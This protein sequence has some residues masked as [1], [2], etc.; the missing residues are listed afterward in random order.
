MNMKIYNEILET[1]FVILQVCNNLK[2]NFLNVP[3]A[4]LLS[5][6]HGSVA[7]HACYKV[8]TDRECVNRP[9]IIKGRDER[10]VNMC[11]WSTW[12]ALKASWWVLGRW[13]C[14]WFHPVHELSRQLA[15]RSLSLCLISVYFSVFLSHAGKTRISCLRWT[16]GTCCWTRFDGRAKTMRRWATFI[17]TTSSCASCRLVK[18]PHVLWKRSVFLITFQRLLVSKCSLKVSK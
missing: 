14:L 9:C 7:L 8:S 1:V 18:T 17:W 5:P 11:V 16:A 13:I 15:D 2:R 3:E 10:D 12:M 6:T 4:V